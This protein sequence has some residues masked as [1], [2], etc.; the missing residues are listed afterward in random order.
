MSYSMCGIVVAKQTQDYTHQV[1]SEYNSRIWLFQKTYSTKIAW[2]IVFSAENAYNT[3]PASCY[4]RNNLGSG[5]SFLDLCKVIP[6]MEQSYQA[7]KRVDDTQAKSTTKRSSRVG[8]LF[9]VDAKYA[10]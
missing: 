5:V 9:C 6:L 10:R 3:L 2:N 4:D 7:K 8:Q 1:R